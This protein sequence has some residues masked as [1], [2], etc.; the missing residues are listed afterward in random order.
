MKLKTKILM[1]I[2]GL[3]ATA[4]AVTPLLVSCKGKS[5][6][7]GNKIYIPTVARAT[8]TDAEKAAGGV[9]TEDA[10]LVKYLTD[11]K[12]NPAVYEQ[13]LLCALSYFVYYMTTPVTDIVKV[14]TIK[15]DIKLSNIDADPTNKTLTYTVKGNLKYENNVPSFTLP[16]LSVDV[17]GFELN[18]V[19]LPMNEIDFDR[20]NSTYN[21]AFSYNTWGTLP[22]GSS[23]EMKVKDGTILGT[24]P[25]STC[26]YDDWSVKFD[27]THPWT[28][29]TPDAEGG[30]RQ[31][32][33]SL[34]NTYFNGIGIDNESLYYG[35]YHMAEINSLED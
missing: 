29:A 33:R 24:G 35:S 6:I 1:P 21:W 26:F 32:A 20:N 16:F 13:D 18:V 30:R 2:I 31:Y 4:A 5:V 15:F 10:G 12:A 9:A 7:D 19:K 17:K 8:Y 27:A 22:E 23:V 11:V 25:T 14:P 34:F 28:P 3:G